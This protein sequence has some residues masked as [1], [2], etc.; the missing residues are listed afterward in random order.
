M[1]IQLFSIS[2]LAQTINSAN[3][4]K[5]YSCRF[6]AARKKKWQRTKLVSRQESSFSLPALDLQQNFFHLCR[7]SFRK[8]EE[9]PKD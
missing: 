9:T 1:L 7:I 8:G 3:I 6:G 5:M 4:T 2:T